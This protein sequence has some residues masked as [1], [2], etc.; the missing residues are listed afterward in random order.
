MVVSSQN[1]FGHDGA[2]GEFLYR[3]VTRIVPLYWIATLTFLGLSIWFGNISLEPAT[4]DVYER[5]IAGFFFFPIDRLVYWPFLN[6]G[7]SLNHEMLFY[8]IFAA[9]IR[10]R[11]SIALASVCA[12][13][14]ALVLVGRMDVIHHIGIQAFWLNGINLEFIWGIVVGLVYLRWKPRPIIAASC[15]AV[16]V[17]ILA[18]STFSFVDREFFLGLPAA[19]IVLGAAVLPQIPAK[20]VFGRIVVLLG[21]ASYALYLLHWILFMYEKDLPQPVLLALAIAMA[22]TVRL[23]IE[24]PILNFFRRQRSLREGIPSHAHVSGDARQRATRM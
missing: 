6:P 20:T 23:L 7:W 14:C 17:G 8:L 24:I 22:I 18:R 21:N 9:T 11:Q 19:L 4:P 16:G 12:I 2:T 3:R 1:L 13:I 5:A 10:L 15:I